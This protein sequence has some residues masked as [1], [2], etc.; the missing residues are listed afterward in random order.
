MSE[1][2]LR[3][4]V[5]NLLHEREIGFSM[6]NANGRSANQ[7]ATELIDN[8]VAIATEYTTQKCKEAR[9]DELERAKHWDDSL[10]SD[11]WP[12]YE[13]K[14]EARIDELKKGVLTRDGE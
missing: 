11:A 12:A 9:V 3:E 6:A 10:V 14:I 4:T 1:E 13:L 7:M 5:S 8:L 2:E